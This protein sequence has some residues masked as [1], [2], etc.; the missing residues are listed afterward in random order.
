ML[1][2]LTWL[3]FKNPHGHGHWTDLGL[4]EVISVHHTF[5]ELLKGAFW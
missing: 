1:E 5:H 4:P 2:K 3:Q